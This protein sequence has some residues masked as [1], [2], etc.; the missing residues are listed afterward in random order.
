VCPERGACPTRHKQRDP[1]DRDARVCAH[2]EPHLDALQR[3]DRGARASSRRIDGDSTARVVVARK[4][5][6]ACR[7][8]WT[9]DGLM[10]GDPVAR[11]VE[12]RPTW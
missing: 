2:G 6:G 3:L 11:I 7:L 8:R 10:D 5:S 4:I 1:S 12:R 9:S